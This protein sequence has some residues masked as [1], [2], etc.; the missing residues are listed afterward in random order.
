M[1]LMRGFSRG[2]RPGATRAP[3]LGLMCGNLTPAMDGKP[4][5]LIRAGLA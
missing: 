1:L 2:P 4:A 3:H 5:L